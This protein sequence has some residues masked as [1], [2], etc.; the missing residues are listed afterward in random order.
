MK[1]YICCSR[2][3]KKKKNIKLGKT[4]IAA[5]LIIT[6][7]IMTGMLS[8]CGH[9]D[10]SSEKFSVNGEVFTEAEYEDYCKVW[11]YEKGY[12]PTDE[13][14]SDQS[15]L[16]MDEMID[17][18]LLRQY[19]EKNEPEL[20]ESE[21]Y[22]SQIESNA[23]SLKQSGSEF[24]TNNDIGDESIKYYFMSEYLADKCFEEIKEDYGESALEED[25]RKYYMDNQGVYGTISF[26][27]AQS[28]ISY[29]LISQKYNEKLKDLKSDA[30]IK[31]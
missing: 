17:T 1:F 19:Y 15:E 24:F 11:L 20:F 12:D 2:S 13:D 16:I 27:N 22:A 9:K 23:E 5:V 31:R 7:L 18:E 8:G 26:E 10:G 14:E 28:E 29:T 30:D 25:A 3:K 6:L 4:G 21:E